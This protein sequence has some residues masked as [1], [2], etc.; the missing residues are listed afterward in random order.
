MFVDASGRRHRMWRRVGVGVGGVLVVGLVLL[1]SGLL[2]NTPL[3][4]PSWPTGQIRNVTTPSVRPVQPPPRTS[5]TSRRAD[6]S[7]TARSAAATAAP[8]GAATSSATQPGN[9]R[10]P[11]HT[12]AKGRPSRPR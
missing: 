3:G 5:A 11:T 7:E 9:G 2:G 12:P 4:T 10:K 6:P 8:P 1:V